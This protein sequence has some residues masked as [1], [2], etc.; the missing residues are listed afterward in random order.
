MRKSWFGLALLFLPLTA[1]A[2]QVADIVA[3]GTLQIGVAE[4]PPWTFTN[5]GGQLEGFEIDVGRTLAHDM[6]IKPVF[7]AYKLDDLLGAVDRGEID[8]IAAGLAITPERALRVEFSS[9]YTQSGTTVVTN[10]KRVT[11]VRKVDD[12]NRKGYVVVTVADTFSATVAAQIFDVAEL[13]T[14]ADE[15]AA[16][17]EIL[18]GRAHAYITNLP[19]ARILVLRHPDIVA[20]PLP[21]AIVGSVAG[22]AVRRGN[23]SMLNFLNAWIASRQADRWL[24]QTHAYW[25]SGYDWLRHA[26]P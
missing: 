2:D 24:P 13:K 3:R 14:V 6:G 1:F 21:E 10:K 9:P 23:Q 4:F 25:F 5:R 22:F 7:K 12:L 19:E 20:L 8:V 16:D 17:K 26:K 11:D 18:E 15:A